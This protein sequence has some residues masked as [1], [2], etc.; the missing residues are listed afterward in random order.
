MKKIIAILNSY[1]KKKAIYQLIKELIFLLLT[2]SILFIIIA[3]FEHIFYIKIYLRSKVV[4]FF[5]SM[6]S[7]AISYIFTKYIITFYSLLNYQNH[8]LIAKELGEKFT[9]IK[10]QLL[11]VLQINNIN[12]DKNRDLKKIATDNMY[13]RIQEL[14]DNNFTLKRPKY[15]PKVFIL[16]SLFFILLILSPS[17]KDASYRLIHYKKK[18]NPPQPFIL[19]NL[20]E[21]ITVLSGDTITI[22][23]AGTGDI[24]DSINFHWIENNIKYWEKISHKKEIYNIEFNNIKSEIIYWA[25]LKSHKLFSRWDVISTNKD[26]VS[27][28][29]RPKLDNIE[30]KISPPEYT[31]IEPF[32][33]SLKNINQLN[34]IKGSQ[35]SIEGEVN[36]K[37]TS[38]WILNKNNNER[39][40]LEIDNN[41]FYKNIL[42]DNDFLF[43]IYYLDDEFIPNLNPK[44][45][46]FICKYDIPPIISIQ[47]P[48]TEFNIDE[49]MIIPIVS[50][51][52]DDFGLSQIYIE[53]EI[54]S[55]DFPTLNQ[56]LSTYM[57]KDQI[58]KKSYNL[59]INWD[60]KN[61]PISM[62]DELHF[63]IVAMD[64]NN[65][66]GNQKSISNTLIGK[67]PSLENLFLEIEEIED[68][69]SDILDEIESSIE[70]ISDF[71]ENIKRDLL[72]SEKTTWDQKEKLDDSFEEI[73]EISSK[74]QEIQEN[75]NT[76]LE[77]ADNNQLFDNEL[78]NKFEKFQE[79]ISN[80]MSNEL[81]ESIEKLQEAIQN[82]DMEDVTKA[83][84][85]FDFNVEQFEQQLDRYIEMFETA[86]AEQKLNEL[87]E[88]MENMID[89][90]ID[91]IEDVNN[92]QD[93]YVLERKSIK[94][95]N[96]FS[97]FKELLEETS[98]TIKSS[99][100]EIS[101]QISNLSNDM[102]TLET[103]NLLHQQTQNT[104]NRS[105]NNKVKDNLEDI[106]N[107]VNSIKDEFQNEL[108][109]KLTKEFIRI[110][111]NLITISNQQE[112]LILQSKDLRSNSPHIQKIN[113]NQFNIDRQFN[114]ITKQLMDLSNTTFFV[115]PKINRLIG[116]LK[117]TISKIISNFEQKN[118]SKAKNNQKESL[119]HINE[120]TYLLLLSME[121]MQ[122]SNA[123]SGFEKFMASL[124]EM[125]QS[126]EGVN[127]GTMQ[128]GSMGMM[129]QQS[130][131]QQL[132]QQQAQLKQ[133]LSD[134][135]SDNP[136]EQ[137][138]GLSKA[139]QEMEEV[140]E[141]FKLNN[142]NKK[143][144]ERQQSILSKMLDSQKSLKQRDFSNKRNSKTAKTKFEN[145]NYKNIPNNYGEKDLFYISAMENALKENLDNN[146]DNMI[147]LYFLNLQKESIE[148][149]N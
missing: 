60:I 34:I 91:F 124:E 65:I 135:I 110:I 134:L 72:K 7:I 95:E 39:I 35:I 3:S 75:I 96:R 103:D 119:G 50:N 45:Y 49:T 51:L 145:L 71:T 31:N 100:T 80:I 32:S 120:I 121:E 94:Q 126:Q 140:I 19:T 64:N 24:P 68:N 30:F 111:D 125:S 70:E 101:D 112:K 92:N 138:G 115:N 54:I 40:K 18:F 58:N 84:E 116:K 86:M 82:L 83:L 132:M 55:E 137:T 109:K 104:Q 130:I 59:D 129:Q 17:Y 61:L 85:N 14:H 44:Q 113:K 21:N 29:Y 38:A 136:G 73:N 128:L 28:K 11:N 107:I 89:K 12:E 106:Q 36:K 52:I 48:S 93:D 78:I 53:Y 5:L 2:S 66:T 56:P 108:S 57:I 87:S 27:I 81:L 9:S 20:S 63:K 74:I 114:Q 142:I 69:T 117:S 15:I 149:E 79:L 77:K 123:A 122:A 133:Q 26:T 46:Y 88:H 90:Q 4:L 118:I 147:R 62:G 6:I 25:E 105:N 1:R 144:I 139:E 141:A 102:I 16:I 8:Y 43:S 10:D 99:S 97:D 67:F 47:S 23:I 131:M 127:Q 148:N 146:Y 143:T 33:E 37:L 41:S 22:N 98:K 76:I 13:I 42:F